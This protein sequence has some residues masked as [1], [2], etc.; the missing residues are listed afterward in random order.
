MEK[1]ANKISV[2]IAYEL[3]LDNDRKEVIAYGTF[4]LLQTIF[5]IGLVIIFGLLFHVLI[6]AIILS[7]ST[8]ILRK[9]SGGAHAS[10]SST[11][12]IAGTIICICQALLIADIMAPSINFMWVF[13]LFLLIFIWA[14]I[15]VFMLAPVDSPAKPI[16]KKER[17]NRMKKI[18]LLILIIYFIIN[19]LI[20][21]L[22]I[23]FGDKR[24]LVYS[25]CLYGGVLWQ[26][27]TLTKPGHSVLG[28]IDYLFN[29]KHKLKKEEE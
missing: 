2:K 19:I 6:E 22:Y 20:C 12:T 21:V 13:I 10:S 5:S 7:F 25:I 16:R 15:M 14:F 3:G 24:F 1:L 4:T 28:A 17:R 8:S 26:V 18:S 9:Y 11:C 23:K 27:F 29:L